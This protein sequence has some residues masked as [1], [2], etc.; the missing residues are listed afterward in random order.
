M[1][2]DISPKNVIFLK[3]FDWEVSYIEVYFTDQNSKPIEIEDK[4][5]ITLVIN[6]SAK[7]KKDSLSSSTMRSNFCKSYGFS[8]SSKNIRKNISANLS[9]K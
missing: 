8:S 7:N 1:H 5:K 6:Y 9:S 3:T 4:I 2:L